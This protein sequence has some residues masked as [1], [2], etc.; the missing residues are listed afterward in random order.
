MGL[1]LAGTALAASTG[2]ALASSPPPPGYF[3]NGNW[4]SGL[5]KPATQFIKTGDTGSEVTPFYWLGVTGPYAWIED[6]HTGQCLDIA[7]AT[8]QVYEASCQDQSTELW[9]RVSDE[10]GSG[11][12]MYV[13][14]WVSD[15]TQMCIWDNL[16]PGQPVDVGGCISDS[17]EDSWVFSS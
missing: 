1:A 15:G 17:G 5:Y 4:G 2:S 12:S 9:I 10:F 11:Y 6:A 7:K 16:G 13:S 3:F 14:D 8:G